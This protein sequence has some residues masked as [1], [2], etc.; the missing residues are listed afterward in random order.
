MILVVI[1]ITMVKMMMV[2]VE[3]MMVMRMMMMTMTVFLVRTHSKGSSLTM[4]ALERGNE[5]YGFFRI[6]SGTFLKI[7]S[8]PL[9]IKNL[10]GFSGLFTA[11][12]WKSNKMWVFFLLLVHGRDGNRN[13]YSI[14]LFKC[15]FIVSLKFILSRELFY[16][17]LLTGLSKLWYLKSEMLCRK[18]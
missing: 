8:W 3:M 13:I 4:P 5:L 1:I 9:R 7:E 12:S 10:T 16:L 6:D 18:M 11:L 17:R 14:F 2:M 15:D